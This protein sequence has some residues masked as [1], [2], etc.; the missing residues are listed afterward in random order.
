MLLLYAGHQSL[1]NEWREEAQEESDDARSLHRVQGMVIE[2]SA[3]S[4]E[5]SFCGEW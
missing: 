3:Y 2:V 5:E 4:A 1:W